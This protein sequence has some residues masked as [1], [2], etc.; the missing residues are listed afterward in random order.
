M[1]YLIFILFPFFCFS[2]QTVEI[3]NDFKIFTY[4]ATSADA[5]QTE[6]TLGNQSFYGDEITI[7]WDQVG[8]F[9]LTAVRYLNNCPSLPQTYTVEVI[10]CDPLLYFIP[11]SFTPNGDEFNTMWGPVF[12]GPFDPQDFNLFVHNR[13][14]EVIWESHDANKKWDGT[15]KG[16]ICSDG[17]YLWRIDFGIIGIDKRISIQGHVNLIK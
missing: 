1:K 9:T 7:V 14:G 11:N 8:V 17:M 3:C 6:W 2:Q 10:E 12:T 13:W 16:K 5:G 15:Y 4:F